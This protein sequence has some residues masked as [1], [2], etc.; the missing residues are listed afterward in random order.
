MAQE[1]VTIYGFVM[2]IWSAPFS[3]TLLTC[4]LICYGQK[5]ML[6]RYYTKQR[7]ESQ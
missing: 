6:G 3:A 1:K 5:S 2:A 7:S 4:D